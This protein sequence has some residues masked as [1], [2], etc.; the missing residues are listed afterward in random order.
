MFFPDKVA[1]L[2]EF[3]RILQKGGK[4]V[5]QV[6]A[7]NEAYDIFTDILRE[8]SGPDTASV[9][10]AP[11]VLGNAALLTDLFKR[12]GVAATNLQTDQV[13]LQAPSLEQWL[14]VEL[15]SWVL[16]GKVDA[17]AILARAKER[18]ASFCMADGT[19]EIPMKG[20]IVIGT[21]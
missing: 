16:S 2:T 14:N 20:H 4:I 3:R 17:A 12:S 19:V 13:V 9:M 5:V 18:M 15:E 10:N 7:Q 21:K 6:W 8:V 1:A 11:F